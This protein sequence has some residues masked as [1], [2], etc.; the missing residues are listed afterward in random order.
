MHKLITFV[1]SA[2]AQVKGGQIKTMTI[3]W[4]ETLLNFIVLLQLDV[5]NRMIVSTK[6]QIKHDL[7]YLLANTIFTN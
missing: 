2:I 3:V 7:Q 6:T 1:I 4:S 5:D